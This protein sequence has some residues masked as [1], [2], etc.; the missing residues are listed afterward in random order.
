MPSDQL[1][2]SV[3]TRTPPQPQQSSIHAHASSGQEEAPVVIWTFRRTGG[4]TLSLLLFGCSSFPRWPGEPFNTDRALGYITRTFIETR[5]TN[6]VHADIAEALKQKHNLKHCLDTVPYEVSSS[7]LQQSTAAGYRHLVLLR[8]NEVR[9]LLSLFLAQQTGAFDKRKARKRYEEI[10]SG[11]LKLKPIEMKALDFRLDQDAMLLGRLMRLLLAN[12]IP[13]QQIFYEDLY[14][15][16]FEERKGL[17]VNL[18]TG[19]GMT[20]VPD[21]EVLRKALM[22]SHQASSS[23]YEYIPNLAQVEA[24]IRAKT[25]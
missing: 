1:E 16:T 5:D 3:L 18:M 13:H 15:G 7:L 25:E 23:V 19:L 9:R 11:Q 14:A 6:R 21:D 8:R 4:T 20:R 22:D 2:S 24:R 10:R 12:Q 17:F